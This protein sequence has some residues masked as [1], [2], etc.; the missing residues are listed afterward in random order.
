M[1]ESDHPMNAMLDFSE[2]NNLSFSTK[3]SVAMKKILPNNGDFFMHVQA[4]FGEFS[5]VMKHEIEHLPNK[6]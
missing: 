3:G 6:K 2:S 5:H 4:G 1:N